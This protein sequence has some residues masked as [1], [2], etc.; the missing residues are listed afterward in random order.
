MEIKMK[1]TDCGKFSL[2]FASLPSPKS[3]L[4]SFYLQVKLRFL[5][6]FNDGHLSHYVDYVVLPLASF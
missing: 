5:S 3:L 6:G 1:E 2:S 4:D